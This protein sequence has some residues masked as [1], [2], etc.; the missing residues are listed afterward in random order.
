MDKHVVEKIVK[1][2]IKDYPEIICLTNSK[3]Q[4][5][6]VINFISESIDTYL[7]EVRKNGEDIFI[8]LNII[9]KFGVSISNITHVI[10]NEIKKNVLEATGIMPKTVSIYIKGIKSKRIAKRDILIKG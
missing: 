3:G 2:T 7:I 5:T 10:I 8:K 4:N 6:K 9:I 1:Y